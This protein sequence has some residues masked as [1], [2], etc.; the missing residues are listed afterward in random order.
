MIT[1]L[2]IITFF[3]ASCSLSTNS[4]V[5]TLRLATTTSTKDSGLLDYILPVFEK[6]YNVKVEVLALGTGQALKTAS[7]GDADVVLVHDKLSEE[8]FV[9]DGFGVKRFDVMYNDFVIVGPKNDPA[10]IKEKPLN[11]AFKILAQGNNSFLSRGDDSGTHKKELSIWHDLELLPEGNWYIVVGKGMG[12]TLIMANELQAYT[13]TDR[14]TY[15]SMKDKLDLSIIIEGDQ[16]LLNPYGVIAVNPA[17][18]PVNY[19]T[20]QK[21]I[22]FL[23]GKEGQDLIKSYKVNGEQLFFTY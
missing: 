3:L 15:L 12:D 2:L 13:L 10:K 5:G 16:L 21:F 20:A 18:Y 8:K 17:K 22:D 4:E 7:L 19:D 1:I 23:L 9:A 6:K 14:A 11:E